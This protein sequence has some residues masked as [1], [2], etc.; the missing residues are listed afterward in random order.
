MRLEQRWELDAQLDMNLRETRAKTPKNSSELRTNTV[1]I[2]SLKEARG[3][4]KEREEEN[5][6]QIAQRA[7]TEKH[8]KEVQI[9]M[10]AN[11]CTE[12]WMKT[13]SFPV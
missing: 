1:P 9:T 13:L 6:W 10:D 5:N 7:H 2:I 4:R 3:E 11:V 12:N 8:S